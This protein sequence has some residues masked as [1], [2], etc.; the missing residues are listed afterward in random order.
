MT[1]LCAFGARCAYRC[2]VAN[3]PGA[4]LAGWVVGPGVGEFA[5]ALC[6]AVE[7][8]G[9]A[10]HDRREPTEAGPRIVGGVRD[11]VGLGARGC[12]PHLEHVVDT[13]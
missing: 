7:V 8:V 6:C 12:L 11:H 1:R 13:D 10:A 4:A 2:V 3:E 5:S 9:E